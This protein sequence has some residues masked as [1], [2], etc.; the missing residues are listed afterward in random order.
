MQRADSLEKT[1]ML[2][3]IEGGR[4]RGKQ[5]INGWMASS[6]QWTWV[7]VNF[8]SWWW[9]GRPGMLQYMG[10][11][12]TWLSL[13]T[14][15]HCKG[16]S[17]DLCQLPIGWDLWWVFVCLFVFPL[18]GKAEWS[19]SPVCWWLGLYF[20]FVCCLDEAFCKV[21]YWW[22]VMPGLVQVVTFVWILTIWYSLGLVLWWSRVLDSVLPLQ[23]LKA[24]SLFMNEDSISGLL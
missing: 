21:C 12:S 3:K 17:S 22:L 6:T 14:E 16:W 18:M 10:S 1:L 9:T 24:W 8:G 19:G 13:W 23:R 15:Q 4:R 11:Q 7:W 5:R 2:W 20:C